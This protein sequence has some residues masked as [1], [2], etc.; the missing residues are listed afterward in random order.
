MERIVSK[1]EKACVT[2]DSGCSRSDPSPQTS[3]VHRCTEGISF[4]KRSVHQTVSAYLETRFAASRITSCKIRNN[5][6]KDW[7]RPVYLSKI[8]AQDHILD[9]FMSVYTE[10]EDQKKGNVLNQSLERGMKLVLRNW[11]QNSISMQLPAHYTEAFLVKTM[12]ELGIGRPSTY[13]LTITTIIS[14]R[15]VAKEQKNL[16]VTE[17][18]EV[19]N[20]IAKQAFLSIVGGKS[21]RLWKG[22]WTVWQQETVSGR[23]C[24]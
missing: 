1:S 3:A 12:E 19:V 6:C 21:L 5:I 4:S 13:A 17:L 22:F 10:E 20:N 18:G 2:E 14:R 11:N 9:G 8:S 16:Y 23:Q 7:C 15:Y 24:K